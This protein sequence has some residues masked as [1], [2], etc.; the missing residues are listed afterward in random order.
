MCH[1]N[2]FE[3]WVR[4]CWASIYTTQRAK[5][6]P[7]TLSTNSHCPI[8]PSVSRN[9]TSRGTPRKCYQ[10]VFVL[11]GLAG[12]T[13]LRVPKV[14]AGRS[15]CQG[16]LPAAGCVAVHG[17]EGPH[18]ADPLTRGWTLGLLV[19]LAL[20]KSAAGNTGD[21]HLLGTLLSKLG[22]KPRRG[23]AGS[24]GRSI[25]NFLRNRPLFST[26]DLER[27]RVQMRNWIFSPELIKEPHAAKATDTGQQRMPAPPA[28][29]TNGEPRAPVM[30]SAMHWR[31]SGHHETSCISSV[32]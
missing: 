3:V 28:R 25:F 2:Q 21:R 13:G 10:A 32:L 12:F 29:S 8:L 26:W 15:R 16:V 17:V 6:K 27:H 20:V 5:R 24:K 1:P 11:W 19:R 23:M 22:Y 9:R 31:W 18:R 30:F 14:H 4:Q 7:S